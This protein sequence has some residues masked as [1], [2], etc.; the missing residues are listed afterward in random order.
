MGSERAVPQV[1]KVDS[2]GRRRY[3]A[4]L[5]HEL[6]ATWLQPRASVAKLSI[7]LGPNPK[8]VCKWTCARGGVRRA[9]R[10]CCR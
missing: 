5:D 8:R 4:K 6:V 10:G 1:V 2:T 9:R 3:S 7:D